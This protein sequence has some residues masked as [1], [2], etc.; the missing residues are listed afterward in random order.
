M[1]SDEGSNTVALQNGLALVRLLSDEGPMT[2]DEMAQRT[3]LRPDTAAKLIKT[4]E[5]HGY[6]EP[7]RF[8]GRYQ[9]GRVAGALSEAFLRGAPIGEVARPVMQALAERH[10]AAVSLMVPDADHA[11]SLLVCRSVAR[12]TP[13]EHAGSTA[14]MVHTA[15]GHALLFTARA[16]GEE[17]AL[18]SEKE[19][20][21]TRNLEDS[22]AFFR[23]SGCF[24]VMDEER[25]VLMLGAPLHL[26]NAVLALEAVV[27]HAARQDQPP[28]GLVGD[29]LTAIEL[30]QQKS[31]AAGVRYL[32]D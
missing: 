17:L 25:N 2:V 15:A 18:P 26:S 16:H 29:L 22:F 31:A 5:L 3:E 21:L 6:I 24:K 10:D 32:D 19:A 23:A 12:N 30:I 4:L 13:T 8:A 20:K 27:P 9:P 1:K 28:I 7:A 14:P 11:L